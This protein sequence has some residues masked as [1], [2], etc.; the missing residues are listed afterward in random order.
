MKALLDAS[1]NKAS[2]M[3]PKRV[4]SVMA[5]VIVFGIFSCIEFSVENMMSDTAKNIILLRV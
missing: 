5:P 2:F 3:L 1:R 4:P